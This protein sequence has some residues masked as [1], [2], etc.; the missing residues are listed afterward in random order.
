MYIISLF[1]G[2]GGLD[3]GFKQSGVNIILANDKVGISCKQ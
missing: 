2:A 1:S 3:L